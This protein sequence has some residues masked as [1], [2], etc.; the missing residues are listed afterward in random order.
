MDQ[1]KSS[2]DEGYDKVSGKPGGSAGNPFLD[3]WRANAYDLSY[4]KYFG[5]KAYFSAQAFYKMMLAPP[6]SGLAGLL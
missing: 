5:N 4:E 3:P 1:L 2:I 6:C